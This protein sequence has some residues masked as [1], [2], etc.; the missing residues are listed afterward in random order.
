MRVLNGHFV[1]INVTFCNKQ[2][3]S[4]LKNSFFGKKQTDLKY[5]ILNWIIVVTLGWCI[6]LLIVEY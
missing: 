2:P 6:V 3:L 1:T 4:F 5:G